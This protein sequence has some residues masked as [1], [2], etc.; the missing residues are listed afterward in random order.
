MS[1]KRFSPEKILGMLREAEVALAQ[2]D[3][4]SPNLW[5][6]INFRAVLLSLA[7]TT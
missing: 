6:V 7:Q 4:Y 3:D 1:R 2:G 5:S